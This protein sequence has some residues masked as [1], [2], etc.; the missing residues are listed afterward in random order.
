MHNFLFNSTDLKTQ[1]EMN[2]F[3]NTWIFTC[4]YLCLPQ[5]LKYCYKY[6]KTINKISLFAQEWSFLYMTEYGHYGKSV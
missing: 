2:I 5:S 4:T 3:E 1:S 6:F